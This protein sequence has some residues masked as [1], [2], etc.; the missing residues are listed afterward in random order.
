LPNA[1]AIIRCRFAKGGTDNI[2]EEAAMKA[3]YAAALGALLTT[4]F[5]SAGLADSDR[6][7]VSWK[8]IIGIVQAGNL[9]FD[10]TGGGQPWSTLGGEARVNLRTGKVEF[11]VRGLV[12]AGGNTIGTPG[13]IAQVKGT[14]ACGAGAVNQSD[15]PLVPLSA[16]GE[17]EFEGNISV[18]ASCT[19][20]NIVF[21]VRI[22]A[23][24]WI[25]NGTVRSP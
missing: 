17:A 13:A 3:L 22:A 24:R 2:R 19:E 1:V 16:Q 6:D 21:L 8:R 14:I 10:I 7:V 15:T 11:D 20:S 9:V 5:A 25:A 12:L 4:G 18:P 23:N